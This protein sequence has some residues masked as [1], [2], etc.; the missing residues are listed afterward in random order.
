V[1][2]VS[3][4]APFNKGK[5]MGIN[6]KNAVVGAATVAAGLMIALGAYVVGFSG[7]PS[8]EG[9]A[10]SSVMA[11]DPNRSPSGVSPRP[12][13]DPLSAQ[14]VE[15]SAS[16]FEHF[17][18]EPVGERDFT[19]QREAVGNIAFNDYLSVQVFPPFQGKIISLFA[20]AGDDVKKGAPLYTIDSPDLVQAGST[21]ISTA[22]VVRLTT[23][24]LERDKKL[25]A[26]Q[27]IPQKE[28][29]QATSDQQ[30]AE[31]ALKAARDAMRIFGKTDADMDRIIAW[32]KIDSVL[33]VRSPI[34]GRV[35]ARN[36]A[37]GLF[38]QPG[39][40]PA[41]YTL[42]DVST[43]WMLA[44]VAETDFPFL[45]LGEEVDVTVKAYPNRVF[46]GRL[47]NIGASVDPTTHRVLVRSAID[48][49]THELRPGMF[50]T[51]VIHTGTAVK[52]PA[53]PLNGVVREG[54]GSMTVWVTTDRKRL[55]KRT[56]TVGLQQGGFAQML[57]G[58]QAGELVATD[59]AL[60]LSNALTEA[61]R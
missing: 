16:E 27:G 54:D 19:I 20:N 23:R 45:Q 14:S 36:A 3:R 30:A 60:F 56:V 57:E 44:N 50:A 31:G 37:P 55:V 32:R 4:T 49:P 26:V 6:T 48:D 22:G 33:V 61:S 35:T 40:A 2:G 17:K 47:V 18:V 11:A 59:G 9:L 46:R 52:S 13:T 42:S 7:H 25:S 58:L 15:V 24:V 51:F 28:L 1:R 8:K 21:L 29:D 5:G 34:T 43:M 53:V 10:H 38:V 39:N 41:P 12:S